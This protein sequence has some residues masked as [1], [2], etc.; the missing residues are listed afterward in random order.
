MPI[1]PQRSKNN[2]SLVPIS[3]AYTQEY[4]DACF[5]AWVTAGQ[6]RG[7][8]LLKILPVDENNRVVDKRV[9]WKWAH[10]DNW[11]KRADDINQRVDIIKQ[12]EVIQ[13]RVEMF[14]RQMEVAR[15][16][17]DEGLGYILD[18]GLNSGTEALRAVV[19]GIRIEQA[20]TGGADML[21]KI[22][23][24]KDE[25]LLNFISKMQV[26]TGGEVIEGALEDVE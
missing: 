19:E 14:R 16:L 18:R 4:K 11:F 24:M 8:E 15:T 20:V 22:A 17:Q 26:E 12:E 6:P 25:E 2:G 21:T 3:T 5:Y 9:F 13:R 1:T 7:N 10:E 23:N